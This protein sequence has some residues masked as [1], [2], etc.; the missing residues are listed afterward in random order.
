MKL[1]LSTYTE[2]LFIDITRNGEV[3]ET[4]EFELDFNDS[5]VFKVGEMSQEINKCANSYKGF[6]TAESTIK[7]A[8]EIVDKVS[9]V[10]DMFAGEGATQ[11]LVSALGKDYKPEDC[12]NRIISVWKY[13]SNK[14][15]KYS[16]SSWDMIS[17][18]YLDE[19]A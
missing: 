13:I 7:H 19:E 15:A 18:K 9:P 17:S 4:L 16:A 1:T 8:R 3:V 11:R 5:N 12:L 2:K 6:E 14:C 10:I